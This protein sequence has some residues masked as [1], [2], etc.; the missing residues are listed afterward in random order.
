MKKILLSVCIVG[1]LLSG[2]ASMNSGG[3]PSAGAMLAGASVGGNVGGAIGGIVG[4]NSNRWNGGWRGSAIGSLVGTVAG[5]AIGGVVSSEVRKQQQKEAAQQQIQYED[6]GYYNQGTYNN[7]Y[8]SS[9]AINPL[10]IENIPFVDANRNRTINP[11]ESSKIIFDIYNDGS[12]AVYNIVPVVQD[13]SKSKAITIS[14][15]TMIECIQPGAGFRYTA[16]LN[17]GKKL[18]PGEITIRVALTSESGVMGDW[19]EFVLN[20]VD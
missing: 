12:E 7:S 5:A 16:T 19:Q 15:S 3:G 9:G 11:N 18:K 8:T 10:Q 2:C 20:C 17:A 1:L 4:S 14:P 13:L 6:N